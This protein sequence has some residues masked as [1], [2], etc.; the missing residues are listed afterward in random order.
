MLGQ[1]SSTPVCVPVWSLNGSA[2]GSAEWL[3]AL[4]KT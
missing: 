4:G 1:A 3:F 2:D